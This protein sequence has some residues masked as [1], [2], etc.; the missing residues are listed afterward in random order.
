[1]KS[2]DMVCSIKCIENDGEKT[3][4]KIHIFAHTKYY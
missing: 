2:I 3:Y 1:M 4:E